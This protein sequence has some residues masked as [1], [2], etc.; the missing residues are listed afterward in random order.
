MAP[1]PPNS[2]TAAGCRLMPS[3]RAP[4][5]AS[6]VA[7]AV[8]A[9]LEA[10]GTDTAFGVISVHN[11]PMLDAVNRR[12]R[13]RFVPARGEAGAGN[14]ADGWA[15]VT[16]RLG[17][18]VT[19]T[20]PGAA[21]AAGAL[22]EA[23][24]AGTPMLH[25]TGQTATPHLDQGRGCV[26]DTP[27]QLNMLR[28]VSKSAYRILSP[29][30]A[31]GI[32]AAAAAE[33]LTAPMGPVSVEIPIDLQGARLP[34]PYE[35]DDFK[36][37]P[38][39]ARAPAADALDRL[40]N[41]IL[42]SRRVLLW[43]GHGAIGAGD[44]AT[45]LADMGIGIVTSMHGRGVLPEDHAMTLGALNATP[46]IESFYETVEAMIV[47]GS[48]LR[49]HETRDFGLRLPKRRFQI[50]VD[51]VAEGRTYPCESFI[52]G[53]AALTLSGL[54]DRLA[55]RFVP[56]PAFAGDL[57]A[58]RAKATQAYRRSLGVYAEFAD[59]MRAA[60]P[61]RSVWV[62]DITLSNST[63]GNRLFPL[64]A[65]R[66]NIYPVGA[67]IGQGLSLGVG[68]AMGAGNRKTVALCGD[69]G[70]ML[71]LGEL[72]TAVQ[73]R[74]DLVVLL[75]NDRGYGVIRNIQDTQYDGRRC[76]ADLALPA[77]DRL[78]QSAGLPYFR[79]G[80]LGDVAP[81]M[82]GALGVNGPSLVEVDMTALGLFP[83]QFAPPP[84]IPRGRH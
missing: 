23:R 28:A 27:D 47:A 57:A 75:M 55:G 8:A 33:A 13:I 83:S 16:G 67:G 65:P 9:V 53:D 10:H 21:N 80:G 19:S 66:D 25:L 79:I 39:L 70:L 36:P 49:G 22:L 11:M 69:G 52:C 18:L 84:V 68:A 30:A 5:A 42:A 35:S 60:L 17:A 54:A 59:L 6:T 81:A 2:C 61:R 58:A 64:Q 62:R 72:W 63:W 50:D 40:A 20:G 15:R 26:H 24:F 31:P 56:D 12:G 73:E 44:A 37:S 51:P 3:D 77:F 38:G 4:A 74:A 7:E 82:G 46:E 34:R 48:R 71:N 29:E 41:D 14:M 78:A 43:L 32:L 45:R 1:S 76:Y